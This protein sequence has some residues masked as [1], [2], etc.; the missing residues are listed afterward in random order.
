VVR[1]CQ[2]HDKGCLVSDVETGVWGGLF[3]KPIL[4]RQGTVPTVQDRTSCQIYMEEL[5][6]DFIIQEV[7]RGVKRM[8]SNEAPGVDAVPMEM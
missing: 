4:L 6:S 8:K 1:S 3:H 7:V 2:E 5:D